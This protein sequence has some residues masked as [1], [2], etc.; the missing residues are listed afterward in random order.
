MIAGREDRL[1]PAERAGRFASALT[2]GELAVVDGAAH[3]VHTE[4]PKA[5]VDIVDAF[6]HG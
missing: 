2:R 4:Q 3:A 5:F 1:F 6:L